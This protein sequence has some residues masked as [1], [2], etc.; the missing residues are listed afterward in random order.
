MKISSVYFVNLVNILIFLSIKSDFIA[1]SHFDLLHYDILGSLPIKTI[2]V[3]ILLYLLII[4]LGLLEFI[5]YIVVL[6]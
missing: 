4:V 3:H 2:G 6:T 1:S 5:F